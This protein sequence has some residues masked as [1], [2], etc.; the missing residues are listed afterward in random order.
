M[1]ENSGVFL[2]YDRSLMARVMCGLARLHNQI[3]VNTFYVYMV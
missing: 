1:R 3:L 2:M